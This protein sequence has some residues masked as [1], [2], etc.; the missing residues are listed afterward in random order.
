MTA[1]KGSLRVWRGAEDRRR[2]GG[3]AAEAQFHDAD[4][5][6]V[7]AEIFLDQEGRLY[8]L[9][10][11]KGDNSPL[12]RFPSPAQLKIALPGPR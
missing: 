5:M 3:S 12:K 6:L 8:E 9:D 11:F 10:V 4:G 2:F 7:S 1:A